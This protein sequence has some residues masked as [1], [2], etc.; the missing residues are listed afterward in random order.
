[1]K[2]KSTKD[3]L[4][5]HSS[6]K[7]DLY[8]KYLS[9]YLNIIQR[10]G[11]KKI[12][13]YDLMC[14]EGVY[15][16]KGKGSPVMAL[17][18]IKQH[19]FSNKQ[20]C[21]DMEVWFNDFGSSDVEKG[22]TKI[23]RVK[24]ACR[25][26]YTPKNVDVIYTNFDFVSEIY[27]KLLDKIKKLKNEKLLLF[28]D[29]YGYKDITPNHIKNILSN[30]VELILF[31]PITPMYRFANKSLKSSDFKGGES[32]KSILEA[33]LNGEEKK[34][35]NEIDFIQTLKDK[36]RDFLNKDFFV[37]TFTI[38]R[39]KSNTYALFFFT[40]HVKGF[41]AM[42][43]TKWH[44]DESNGTGFKIKDK[45]QILLFAD[46]NI[47]YS[48]YPEK[49]KKHLILNK[50]NT[51]NR[52]LYIFGLKNGYLP[53]HTNFILK[54]WKK[55]KLLSVTDNNGNKINSGFYNSYD[56]YNAKK[57]NVVYFT[58]FNEK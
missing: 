16:D 34:F 9:R 29:P 23:E 28:L 31:V 20:N 43:E 19:F 51:T 40:P 12:H 15:A 13:L 54:D 53:K 2:G 5:E 4:L 52:E 17:E 41:E 45:D 42:L 21:A 30:S 11:F 14:G 6:V 22:K 39:D 56:Y 25:N 46:E 26:I 8:I 49:L 38:Q 27:P 35:E 1:M 47:Y 10:A 7:V 58:F 37:D 55:N 50:G 18:T 44:L 32:L 57:P 36:Y 24:S 48:N 3:I 33:L